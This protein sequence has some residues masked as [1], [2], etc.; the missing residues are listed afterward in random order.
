M[1]LHWFDYATVGIKHPLHR[2]LNRKYVH[3]EFVSSLAYSVQNV[4][5]LH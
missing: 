3:S 5:A 4:P 1:R 2:V